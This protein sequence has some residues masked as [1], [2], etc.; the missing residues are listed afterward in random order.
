L[1]FIVS[2]FTIIIV[3][4]KDLLVEENMNQA[5][6]I[7]VIAE[8]YERWLAAHQAKEEARKEY[9]IHEGPM[10]RDAANPN[11]AQVTLLHDDLD[12]AMKWFQSDAFKEGVREAGNVQREIWLSQKRGGQ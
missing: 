11:A 1:T 8:D 7:R 2:A 10:Y 9:G 12:K 5:I 6:M 3:T 4:S